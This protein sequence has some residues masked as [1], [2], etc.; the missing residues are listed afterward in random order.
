[1]TEKGPD[2]RLPHVAQGNEVDTEKWTPS[3]LFTWRQRENSY[4]MAT[5][6]HFLIYRSMVKAFP[7][8][9]LFPVSPIPPLVLGKVL[10]SLRFFRSL[11]VSS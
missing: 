10:E 9:F 1:M 5:S 7:S 8:L 6:Q 11:P 3:V 4:N 2:K